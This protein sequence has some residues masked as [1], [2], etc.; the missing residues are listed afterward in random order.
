MKQPGPPT[1]LAGSKTETRVDESVNGSKERRVVD[2]GRYV[3]GRLISM[4]LRKK[5][6]QICYTQQNLDSYSSKMVP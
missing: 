5:Q 6:N 3:I 4:F 1:S 2:Q